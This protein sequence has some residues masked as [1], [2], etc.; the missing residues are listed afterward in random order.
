MTTERQFIVVWDVNGL[1]FCGDYTE[2]SRDRMWMELQDKQSTKT[3]PSLMHLE[4]RARNNI[5]RQY[6]IYGITVVEG[7]TV[8]DV[9]EAFRTDAESAKAL[10]RNNGHCYY[11]DAD[12]LYKDSAE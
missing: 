12:S 2:Y 7:V 3:F 4:L 6:E 8:D 9:I 11:S 1:E 10:I 5:S